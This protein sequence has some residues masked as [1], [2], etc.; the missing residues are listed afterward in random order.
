MTRFTKNPSLTIEQQH[1]FSPRRIYENTFQFDNVDKSRE[2]PKQ[3]KLWYMV[4]NSCKKSDVHVKLRREDS[5]Q[6]SLT[7][8]L[9]KAQ[10]SEFQRTTLLPNNIDIAH[11]KAQLL[12]MSIPRPAQSTNKILKKVEVDIPKS[13]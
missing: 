6:W 5:Q 9:G 3:Y 12:E 8:W 4:P 1:Y 13:D 7:V 2:T 10:E 11:I